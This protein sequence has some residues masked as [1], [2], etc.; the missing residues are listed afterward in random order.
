MA[1]EN[2]SENIQFVIVPDFILGNA[3]LLF[4]EKIFFGDLAS[5]CIKQGFCWASNEYFSQKYRVTK[6]N[7]SRW[8][9]NL[10]KQNLISVEMIYEPEVKKIKNRKVRLNTNNPS[11]KKFVDWYGNKCLYPRDTNVVPP[12]DTNVL[13]NNKELNS[14]FL[15]NFKDIKNI[16][17]SE[18]EYQSLENAYDKQ[19]IEK[20]IKN[21]SEWKIKTNAHPR[22]DFDS[23]KK[24]LDKSNSKT[25]KS[26]NND[27]QK[28]ESD[29]VSDEEIDNLPF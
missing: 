16:V 12:V 17:L 15:L 22:S 8:V 14:K 2:K 5:H 29:E 28:I 23:L 26:Y 6:R 4:G 1:T 3:N 11:V 10:K 25:Y 20:A 19:K 7:I 21:F 18:F 27:A 9:G 24:L 13:E